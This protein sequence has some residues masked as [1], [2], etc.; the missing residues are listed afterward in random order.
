MP[1]KGWQ[2]VPGKKKPAPRAVVSHEPPPPPA[3]QKEVQKGLHPCVRQHGNCKFERCRYEK[4]PDHYCSHF[5]KK[6]GCKKDDASCKWVHTEFD[7]L[8]VPPDPPAAAPAPAK[9][10]T[11]VKP[12]PRVRPAVVKP[13]AVVEAAVAAAAEPAAVVAS[14]EAAAQDFG[15]GKRVL[16]PGS[17]AE[18]TKRGE[19]SNGVCEPPVRSNSKPE[20]VSA[21]PTRPPGAQLRM[22]VIKGAFVKR[23]RDEFMAVHGKDG[24]RIWAFSKIV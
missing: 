9:V 6:S 16:K 21:A 10:A 15:F 23:S 22:D 18:A 14:P 2:E 5:I 4:C 11:V 1:G 19:R 20:P 12:T 24:E 17:Y 8:S 3:V 13:A 7:H